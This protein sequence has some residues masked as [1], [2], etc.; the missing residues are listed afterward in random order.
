MLEKII[1]NIYLNNTVKCEY[2]TLENSCL[3]ELG[4]KSIVMYTDRCSDDGI[5]IFGV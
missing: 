3:K 1:A 4:F 5:A 2:R